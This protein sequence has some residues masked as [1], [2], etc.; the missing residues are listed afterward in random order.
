[1]KITLSAIITALFFSVSLTSIANGFEDKSTLSTPDMAKC[2]AAALKTD[3]DLW[4]KWY[5]VL[6]ARYAII[7][8]E[9]SPKEIENYTIERVIDKR[10]D[11]NRDGIDSKRA[12]LD[13]FKINC[14][15]EI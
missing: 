10:R 1:M 14:E 13:Y 4:G 15:G 5:E 2:A 3:Q 7:Y 9:K 8:K 11:L 6:K 12:Y